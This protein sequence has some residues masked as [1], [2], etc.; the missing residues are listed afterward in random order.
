MSDGY[1]LELRKNS[2]D[3]Y[4]KLSELKQLVE[5]QEDINLKLAD[6][7]MELEG[8]PEIPQDLDAWIN[9]LDDS[10]KRFKL[11]DYKLMLSGTKLYDKL[12]ELREINVSKM[13]VF[14]IDYL[15]SKINETINKI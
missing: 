7:M 14:S 6:I 12:L 8:L 15:I 10:D 1:Q 11:K 4:I 13:K 5:D 3:V 2:D 9:S